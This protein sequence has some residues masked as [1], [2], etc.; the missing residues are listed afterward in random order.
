MNSVT[1]PNGKNIYIEIN[2][3]KL[4]AAQDC[5]IR[6]QR[7]GHFVRGFGESEADGI[8]VGSAAHS[9]ELSRIYINKDCTANIYELSGFDLTVIKPDGKILFSGCQW[10]DITENYSADGLILENVCIS[11]LTR[12]NL[13]S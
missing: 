13:S 2:G 9:I 1:I 11:A 12:T 4:A 3:T 6:S 7:T 10:E 5:K 8:A